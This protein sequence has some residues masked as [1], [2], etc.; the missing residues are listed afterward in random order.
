[1]E[2]PV[3]LLELV[4]SQTR[5]VEGEVGEEATAQDG[6]LRIV[7]LEQKRLAQIQG[8]NL[9]SAA[10]LPEVHLIEVWPAK[11]E[12][13]PIPVGD[14]YEGFHGI[15]AVRKTDCF[16]QSPQEGVADSSR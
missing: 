9:P 7:Q 3:L 11:E 16:I 4:P 12:L 13:V 8:T 1:M 2:W 6:I 10:R 15:K 14:G 5:R